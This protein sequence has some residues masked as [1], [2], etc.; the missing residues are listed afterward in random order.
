MRRAGA[1][2]EHVGQAMRRFPT[3]AAAVFRIDAQGR[4]AF[5]ALVLPERWT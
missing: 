5:E 3:A 2:P 4:P 1:A